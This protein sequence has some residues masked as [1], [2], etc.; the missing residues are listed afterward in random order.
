MAKEQMPSTLQIPSTGQPDEERIKNATQGAQAREI[1]WD[2][3]FTSSS[4]GYEIDIEFN[5]KK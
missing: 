4:Q 1:V 5:Y 3:S 2:F